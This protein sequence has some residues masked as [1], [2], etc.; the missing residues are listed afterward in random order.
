MNSKTNAAVAALLLITGT[1]G[2]AMA[3]GKKPAPA[4]TPAAEPAPAAVAPD[5]KTLRKLSM[6]VGEEVEDFTVTGQQEV[7]SGAYYTTEYT[8]LTRDGR[9]YKCE[10]AEPSKFAKAMSMG[11]GAGG[12]SAVCTEFAS[13]GASA[14]P[15][16]SAGGASRQ[17]SAPAADKPAEPA[18]PTA[19]TVDDKTLRK[20]SMGIGEEVGEFKVTGQQEVQSGAYYT[21]EYTVMTNDGRKYKCE[22]ME[23]SKFAKVMSWG[24]GA[25]GS[26]AVC[27]DFTKGSKNKGK[28]NQASCNPLLRA[29]G[30]CR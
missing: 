30:Q 20:I 27:T 8:L 17:A 6:G 11:T 28:I 24:M 1:T 7:Q 19:V 9:K 14:R 16:A 10:V 4:E 26:S 25:G 22:V 21:T 3:A 2:V 13:K 18:A 5:A 29:S 15:A 23:A 12:S